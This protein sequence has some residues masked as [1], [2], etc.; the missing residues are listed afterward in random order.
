MNNTINKTTKRLLSAS[1][2]NIKFN[3]CNGDHRW[4]VFNKENE[5]DTESM[6]EKLQRN[7]LNP[8]EKFYGNIIECLNFIDFL[9]KKME[10][11]TLE[12]SFDYGN[13][14]G[15]NDEY[16]PKDKSWEETGDEHEDDKYFERNVKIIK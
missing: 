4:I 2:L 7:N 5:D 6:Y 13:F 8:S 11:P 14:W 12:E 3:Y 1:R 9:L 15:F 10:E 16:I